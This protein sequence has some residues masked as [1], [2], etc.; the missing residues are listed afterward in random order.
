MGGREKI[1]RKDCPMNQYKKIITL[2]EERGEINSYDRVGLALQ[3]PAR[4]YY[5]KRPPYNLNIESRRE[6][7][8]SVTYVLHKKD[9]PQEAEWNFTPDGKAY[10]KLVDEKPV[11]EALL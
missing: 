4:V 1:I 8:G 11:Q 6:K 3:L 5:L 9:V 10:K 2:L 7:N